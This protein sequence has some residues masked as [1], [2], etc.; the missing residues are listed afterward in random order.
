MRLI[1]LLLAAL[2]AAPAAAENPRV[3]MKTSQGTIVLEIFADRAPKSAANFMQYVRDGF[4]N[5]TIFHRVIDGFMIQGGGFDR[6]MVQKTARA[7]IDNEAGNGLKNLTGTLAMART[8]NPH[9]ASAQ[10]FINLKDNDFLNYREA[11]PQGYGYAV[12]GK[13]TQGMDVVTKIAKLATT[14]T[15]Q[16]QNVPRDPVIIES[17]SAVAVK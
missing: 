8:P 3:E 13:V 1:C 6:G 5:G 14:T 2:I 12:F 4:Y 16:F 11:T 7:P 15:G 10:F 17:V 9:S